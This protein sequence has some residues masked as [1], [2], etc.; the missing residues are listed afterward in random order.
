MTA[1]RTGKSYTFHVVGEFYQ[2]LDDVI[3]GA[4]LETV[5]GVCI[6]GFNTYMSGH[7][8][9]AV[10]SDSVIEAKLTFSLPLLLEGKYLV[11]PAIARGT[12]DTH[13]NIA[14]WPS[15]QDVEIINQQGENL[16]LVEI[17]FSKQLASYK[18]EYIRFV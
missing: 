10:T 11:S 7:Q 4:I 6:L 17:P 3:F 1:L 13:I 9:Y 18:R 15:Y 12:Q 14:W 5:Q 16:S 8:D 2:N